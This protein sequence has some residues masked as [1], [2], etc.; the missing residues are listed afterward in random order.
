MEY[1]PGGE[2]FDFVRTQEGMAESNAREMFKEILEGVKHCHDNGV[3]H[4]DLKLENILLDKNNKP[5][6]RHTTFRNNVIHNRHP[7]F[8]GCGEIIRTYNSTED[9]YA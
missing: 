4:R 6:V 9:E 7:L 8:W 5:K 1:I 3:A 2:L